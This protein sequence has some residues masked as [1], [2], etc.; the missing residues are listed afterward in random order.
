MIIAEGGGREAAAARVGGEFAR[1]AHYGAG[2]AAGVVVVDSEAP[3]ERTSRGRHLSQPARR[4]VF[5][6]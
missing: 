4:E 6:Q 2:P 3:G 1:G 5:G